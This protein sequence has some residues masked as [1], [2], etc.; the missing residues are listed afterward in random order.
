MSYFGGGRNRSPNYNPVQFPFA[1]SGGQD[2]RLVLD[3][4]PFR[5]WGKLRVLTKYSTNDR[6]HTLGNRNWINIRQPKITADKATIF[7]VDKRGIKR[8]NPYMTDWDLRRVSKAQ[9]TNSRKPNVYNPSGAFSAENLV[10]PGDKRA[11]SGGAVKYGREFV[12]QQPFS[13]FYGLA[14]RRLDF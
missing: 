13:P 12:K 11:R 10:T 14:K 9:T 6:R 5:P 2:K 7:E 3:R 8:P 1:R 4:G